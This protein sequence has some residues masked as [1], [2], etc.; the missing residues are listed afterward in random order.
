MNLHVSVLPVWKSNLRRPRPT[1][2]M[3]STQDLARARLARDHKRLRRA[4]P[5]QR[6]QR[7]LGHDERVRRRAAKCRV[8][9]GRASHAV[10]AVDVR[11]RLVGVHGDQDA[12]DVRVDLLAV[13]AHAQRAEHGGLRELVERDHVFDALSCALRRSFYRACVPLRGHLAVRR[14]EGQR[15]GPPDA[16][17]LG[18]AAKDPAPRLILE[19]AGVVHRPALVEAAGI[20]RHPR[21]VSCLAPTKLPE[22]GNEF[23]PPE[24]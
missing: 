7:L 22:R 14:R 21:G 5:V 19:K 17:D 2:W 9:G 18:D 1:Y 4:V 3:I 20:G 10:L 11:D 8:G 23:L 15:R 16:D 6:P 12:P 24:S 13:V